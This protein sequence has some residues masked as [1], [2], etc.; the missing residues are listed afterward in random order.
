MEDDFN[1]EDFL[2]GYDDSYGDRDPDNGLSKRI[3]D[4]QAK[5]RDNAMRE[6]YDFIEEVGILFWVRRD[7]YLKHNRK[8]NI[9]NSMILYFQELEE[10]EKCAYLVK[11]LKALESIKQE[12][13]NTN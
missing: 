1:F 4:F 13:S 8:K 12:T 3:E 2:G 10:Y 9:L 11:G 6:A 5:L 7:M